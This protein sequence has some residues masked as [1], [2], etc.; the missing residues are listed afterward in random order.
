MQICHSLRCKQIDMS[1]ADWLISIFGNNTATALSTLQGNAVTLEL[2]L[3]SCT[4]NWFI[5]AQLL[6]HV[7]NDTKAKVKLVK[8][9][10][11]FLMLFLMLPCTKKTYTR[12]VHVI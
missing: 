2:K 8:T 7:G 3:T 4:L 5:T 12:N 6:F 1:T 9:T 10:Q 11:L